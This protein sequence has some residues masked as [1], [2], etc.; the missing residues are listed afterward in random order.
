MNGKIEYY[1]VEKYLTSHIHCCNINSMS[2]PQNPWYTSILRLGY[3]PLE[4]KTLWKDVS[5]GCE[6]ELSS[7]LK[8]VISHRSSIYV[9]KK[10]SEVIDQLVVSLYLKIDI[11][12]GLVNASLQFS[13]S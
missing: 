6:M 1:C 10:I 2:K 3:N 12:E 9:N 7:I 8:L 5:K 11:Y 13:I 4:K